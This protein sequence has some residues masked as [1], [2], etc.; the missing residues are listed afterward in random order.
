MNVRSYTKRLFAML[1]CVM[2]VVGML[3][4]TVFAA[5]TGALV[6]AAIFCSDVHGNPD[7][8]AEVFAGIDSTLNPSTA[9]FVGDTD[10]STSSVTTQAQS[11]FPGAKCFYAY[12]SHDS[13][14][15]DDVTDV[16]YNGDNYAIY[17][18]SQSDMESYSAAKTASANF[19][20]Q[21]A[22]VAESKP[23]FILSHMPL[24]ARRSDNDG[25]GFWC[26][27]INA[28]A[29]SRDIVFF[30]AHNHTGET[31]ADTNAYYVAKGSTMTVEDDSSDNNK[32]SKTSSKSLDFTY[33]NAGYIDA[34]NQNPAR[35]PVATTVKI[36]ADSLIFQDYTS[37]GA[38]TG[39]YSHN[40][41]VEREFAAATVVAPI[42]LKVEGQTEYTVGDEFVEPTV[43]LVYEDTSL[44]EVLSSDEYTQNTQFS[45][46]EAGTYTLKYTYG[47]LSADFVITVAEAPVTLESIAVS[48]ETEYTVGDELA[49]T[50]TATYSD[51]TTKDVTAD[52]EITG[53]DM[54]VAGDYTVTATYE[55][56]TAT[57]EITVAAAQEPSTDPTE[58]E[59]SVSHM[60]I[61]EGS[62]VP[63]V[64]GD[65]AILYKMYVDY[66]DGTDGYATQ[67]DCTMV[68]YD[69]NNNV[70]TEADAL[71]TPGEYSAEIT[72]LGF[73]CGTKLTFT[74]HES[75]DSAYD[76]LNLIINGAE[77]TADVKNVTDDAAVVAAM[78]TLTDIDGYVA[79]DITADLAEG[80][81]ATV[82]IPVSTDWAEGEFAVYYITDEGVISDET[83]EPTYADGY[84]TFTATHFSTYTVTVTLPGG[85]SVSTGGETA[86]VPDSDAVYTAEEVT[87]YKRV[88]APVANGSYLIVSATNYG[89]GSNATGYDVTALDTDAASYYTSWNGSTN[90]GTLISADDVYIT[91]SDAFPWEVGGST[92]AYTFSSGSFTLGATATTSSGCDGSTTNPSLTFTGTT[93]NSTTWSYTNN[94]LTTTYDDNTINLILSGSS[95]DA[96]SSGSAT[97]YFYEPVKLTKV[98]V[99]GGG[100]GGVYKAT[101]TDQFNV[102]T[103]NGKT[104]TLA[105]TLTWTPNSTGVESTV[106]DLTNWTVKY[107]EVSDASNIISITDNGPSATL[108]GIVGTAT[109]SVT[110]QHATYGTAYDDFVITTKQAGGTTVTGTSGMHVDKTVELQADGTYTINLEAFAT[111]SSVRTESSVEAPVDIVLVLDCSSSMDEKDIPTEYNADGTVKTYIYRYQALYNAVTTFVEKV[112]TKAAGSNGVLGDDDDIAHRISIV[113]YNGKDESRAE[114]QCGLTDV[115]T[116]AGQSTITTVKSPLNVYNGVTIN[117]KTVKYYGSGTRTDYG[118][119]GAID[120]FDA[121]YSNY[122]SAISS[123]TLAND[124]VTDP[125]T[126]TREKVV[127]LFTDGYPSTSGSTNFTTSYAHNAVTYAKTLKNTYGAD[128]YSLLILDEDGAGPTGTIST[129]TSNVTKINAMMHGISS[130]YVG[131][132]SSNDS[133]WSISFGDLNT[134]VQNSSGTLD[135]AKSYYQYAADASSLNNIFTTIANNVG[136]SSSTTVTLDSESVMKDIIGANFTVPGD[137]SFENVE[138]K[139]VTAS[140]TDGTNFTFGTENVTDISKDVTYTVTDSTSVSGGKDINITGFSYSDYYVTANKQGT[141]KDN[142]YKLMVTI[143]GIKVANNAATDTV[144]NT[145]G[146]G[147]GIY[148]KDADASTVAF[149]Q[150]KSVVT[151]KLY[152]LDYAKDVTLD[153]ADWYAKTVNLADAYTTTSNYG[154]WNADGSALTYSP[155]T[156][157]WGG[158]DTATVIGE[159]NTAFA[160]EYPAAVADGASAVSTAAEGDATTAVAG[161]GAN[162]QYVLSK[163]SV[164][165]ANNVYYEDS[166][167][168]SEATGNVGIEFSDGWTVTGTAANNT[169]VPEDKEDSGLGKVH[170]WIDSMDNDTTFSDGTAHVSST[171]G[172]T[173]TFSFTG[174][175]V[176]IYSYTDMDSGIVMAMLYKDVGTTTDNGD[177]TTSNKVAQKT[178]MVD[179]LAV[180]GDYYQIPTLSFNTMEILDASTTD[181]ATDVLGYGTYTVKLYVSAGKAVESV[182]EGTGITYSDTLK[183]STY[184]LDGIRVY[185]PLGATTNAYTGTNQ[186]TEFVEIRDIILEES[187]LINEFNTTEI[188]NALFIDLDSEGT[189]ASAIPYNKTEFNTYGPKNEVYLGVDQTIAFKVENTAAEYYVGLKSPTGAALKVYTFGASTASVPFSHTT[190][191]YYKLTPNADGMICIYNDASSGGILS[192]T[193]IQMVGPEA[194]TFALR[195]MTPVEATDFALASVASIEDAEEIIPE[196]TVPEETVPEETVP[197]ETVPEETVPEE[198]VPDIK[199]EIENK[200]NEAKNTLRGFVNKLFSS[201]SGWF[202]R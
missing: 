44:N 198:T 167:V 87:V 1:L 144:F 171:V 32:S 63:Y 133:S 54:S 106:T 51:N 41:T 46:S 120:V 79:Y 113:T 178:L 143:S 31:S 132:T 199:V 42:E 119:Q 70:V 153:E 45:M 38:F 89:L 175:G 124:T 192:V 182:E 131:A 14:Y 174:T 30:W 125:A 55:N 18:I 98:T 26:D 75:G 69:A 61:N 10:C 147:S 123:I 47:D 126:V 6:D 92:G 202:G 163:V 11:V 82:S 4:T 136:N 104:I 151:S 58:A 59:K 39:S 201:M 96:S 176:D 83:F 159:V 188:N 9:S 40:V 129:T 109:L 183:R 74:V 85:G 130:N 57:C 115:S 97:V 149:P 16:L 65:E 64:V 66:T 88:S 189:T 142:Q 23:L 67:D 137:T 101:G 146:E 84:V 13:G 162:K 116:A 135:V 22:D 194:T 141:Y 179:N 184:Y 78:A 21:I 190:D 17:A 169:E 86:V 185:N 166:F 99:S 80:A 197:E 156:T 154:T 140:T 20:S 43:T 161:N 48:G 56:L 71:A 24:H 200:V 2:L 168:T 12:G 77:V 160:T 172:S 72:Y 152:V 37:S 180:S 193:K 196:E 195:R 35:K 36:T 105:S 34:N 19:A 90:T 139:V 3:P 186:K 155:K 102:T 138:I 158:F 76:L 108:S 60:T 73:T 145:N 121:N 134:A 103:S 148:A 53:A 110:Y 49:L 127:V 8:V 29:A 165:P 128:V 62:G 107:T 100:D 177:G 68:I 33:M 94:I 191:Q 112:Y 187:N 173:A 28:A 27:A 122:S 91:T 81:T 117:N 5:E 181:D 95:W 150:P 93:N 157:M 170:G 111:G 7:A 15:V 25:A 114:I 164:I 118:L 50:V 52:A